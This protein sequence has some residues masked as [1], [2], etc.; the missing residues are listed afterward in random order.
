MMKLE[1]LSIRL[2]PKNRGADAYKLTGIAA[3][4]DWVVMSDRFEPRITL[5][6]K[7][8]TNTP[9][10]IFLSLR[11]PL[12]ALTYFFEGILPSVENR[13]VLV[14][15]SEDVTVP[16]Q[17]DRRWR[18]YDAREKDM[19]SRIASHP[20]LIHWYA[21]NLAVDEHPKISPLPTGLVDPDSQEP[22]MTDIPEARP[23]ADRPASVL[24]A[25]RVR[26]GPQWDLRKSVTRMAQQHWSPFA[27]IPEGELNEKSFNKLLQ[28]NAF[29]ACVE[30][31]GLDPSP[32][33][34][35]AILHGAIPIIRSTALNR[36]YE[37]L[38]VVQVP[39]WEPGTLTLNTLKEWKLE[40]SRFDQQD[41]RARVLERLSMDYWFKI[42]ECGKPVA[43]HGR[44]DV[45][46]INLD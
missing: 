6:R 15:G 2:F 24:V 17:F 16:V 23:L 33:A 30:G 8:E 43:S 11:S 37:L 40:F 5:H 44:S 21:E 10:H 36:A 42:I 7:G 26:K 39:N 20:M 31:G 34:W 45:F 1:P 9:R 19:L 25:H 22:W 3:R 28:E 18:Q 12:T 32:K 4:C 29:V 13:F 38:P 14:T 46:S 27:T 41:L 35:Q